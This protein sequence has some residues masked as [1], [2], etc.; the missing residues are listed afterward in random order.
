[1]VYGRR[2]GVQPGLATCF[3]W[4]K[5][6]H[7]LHYEREGDDLQRLLF[8]TAKTITEHMTQGKP[9]ASVIKVIIISILY[10]DLG[11]GSDYV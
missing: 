10:F 3:S 7:E 5:G 11:H 1:M 8:S 4:Q 2:E 6:Y 9:Y